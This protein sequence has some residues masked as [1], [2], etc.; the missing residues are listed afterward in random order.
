MHDILTWVSRWR[1]EI[2]IKLPRY[3]DRLGTR[4]APQR[5]PEHGVTVAF[6]KIVNTTEIE[7]YETRNHSRK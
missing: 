2:L 1:C 5:L 4:T 7:E 6:I 3:R